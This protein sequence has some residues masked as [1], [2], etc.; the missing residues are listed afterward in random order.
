MKFSSKIAKRKTSSATNFNF[1]VEFEYECDRNADMIIDMV[2]R[3][4]LFPSWTERYPAVISGESGEIYLN[5]LDSRSIS[6]NEKGDVDFLL[7]D[8]IEIE[9]M[10]LALPMPINSKTCT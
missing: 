4:F 9:E 8:K 2:K 5:M 3:D 1:Q 7:E 10:R 6:F